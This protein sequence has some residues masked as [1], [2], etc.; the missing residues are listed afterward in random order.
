MKYKLKAPGVLGIM[1]AALFSLMVLTHCGSEETA[2]CFEQDRLGSCK[3]LCE[4]GD[5]EACKKERDLGQTD[6]FED[7]NPAACNILC[8]TDGLSGAHPPAEPYCEKQKEL[9][10]LEEHKDSFDCERFST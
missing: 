2:A 8:T 4:K 9:C 10:G 7:E 5:V 3:Y 1:G 6:C